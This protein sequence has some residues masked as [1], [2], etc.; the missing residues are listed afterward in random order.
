VAGVV[1][2]VTATTTTLR[3]NTAI[4]R[5]QRKPGTATM[6]NLAGLN[7]TEASAAARK[8][9]V[10]LRRIDVDVPGSLPGQVVGQSPPAGSPVAG[11]GE[12]VAETTPGTP[13][14]KDP[15]PDLIGQAAANAV[16]PLVAKGWVIAQTSVAAPLG[17]LLPSGLAPTSGQVW[18]STPPAGTV[19]ADGHVAVNVQP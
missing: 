16:P 7:F 3:S 18:L 14:P 11:A 13:P 4:F 8:A 17:F 2:G 1:D 5:P 15:F 19:T 6:P 12:T 10:R 9:G